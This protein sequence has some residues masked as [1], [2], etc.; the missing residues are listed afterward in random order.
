M[1]FKGSNLNSGKSIPILRLYPRPNNIFSFNICQVI[2]ALQPYPDHIDVNSLQNYKLEFTVI[3][4]DNTTQNITLEKYF[5]R[6]G[7]EKGGVNEWH[8]SDGQPLLISKWVEWRG[9]MLPGYAKKIMGSIIVDFIPASADTYKMLLPSGCN[10]KIIKFLNS[11]G[12]Y[13]FWVFESSETSTKS[14]GKDV[15][16]KIPLYLSADAFRNVG[17]ESS[18]E[19]TMKTKTPAELQPIIVD[20][21]K[22]PEVLLYDPAGSDD[23]S[24]WQRLQLSGSNGA[25]LNTTD[26]SYLNEL[27]FTIYNSIN[28]DL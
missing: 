22:S 13:Q 8:L 17:S 16:S 11:L 12:V 19:I 9:L 3:F 15:V 7:K 21:I 28:R 27:D 1:E 20:L 25:I 5:V 4:D 10:A 18:T 6:G 23:A 2:R 26:M 24:S 14:K